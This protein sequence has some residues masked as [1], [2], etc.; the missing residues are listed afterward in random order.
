MITLSTQH[1]L[2][3]RLL[4]LCRYSAFF[5]SLFSF[6]LSPFKLSCTKKNHVYNLYRILYTLSVYYVVNK[7][8]SEIGIGGCFLEKPITL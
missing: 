8:V 1:N 5:I 6:L 2:K 3:D 7:I 4:I